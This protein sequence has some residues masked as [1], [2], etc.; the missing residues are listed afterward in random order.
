MHIE[1]QNI[2]SYLYR[3][4]KGNKE[5][6]Q[7]YQLCM[8]LSHVKLLNME[9]SIACIFNK[10][11]S[12]KDLWTLLSATIFVF[13]NTQETHSSNNCAQNLSLITCFH[14]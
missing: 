4:N 1:I 3:V 12:R 8:I 2:F 7:F 9:I 10:R 6:I 13:N 5:C 14:C 11:K